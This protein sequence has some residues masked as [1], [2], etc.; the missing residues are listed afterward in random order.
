MVSIF[1]TWFPQFTASDLDIDYIVQ[2]LLD[3]LINA[4]RISKDKTKKSIISKLQEKYKA[5]IESF[6]IS[7]P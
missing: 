4:V 3:Y 2:L 5:D 1:S 7:F 6:K